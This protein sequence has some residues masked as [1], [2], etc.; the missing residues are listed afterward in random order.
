MEILNI[1]ILIIIHNGKGM[2]KWTS[3]APTY[4]NDMRDQMVKDFATNPNFK[5]L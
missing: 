1:N 2:V 4:S 3:K 5:I